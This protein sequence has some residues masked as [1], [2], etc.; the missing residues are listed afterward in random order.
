MRL[1][2]ERVITV[3]CSDL[4]DLSFLSMSVEQISN[5]LK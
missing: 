3:V 5:T 4:C 1:E 2:V